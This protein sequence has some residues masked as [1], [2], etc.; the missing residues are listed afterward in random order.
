LQKR[1]N[2][3]LYDLIIVDASDPIG[4]GK[5]LYKT[6]FY[7]LLKSVLR[8][9]G[10]VAVQG[11]SFFWLQGV[12]NTVYHQLKKVFPVV[13]PYQCFTAIYPGGLW[14]LH[15]ATLGDDPAEVDAAV[16]AGI[17]TREGITLDYYSAETH[18]AS[19][20]LPPFAR[21]VLKETPLTLDELEVLLLASDTHP[22][23]LDFKKNKGA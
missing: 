5:S 19:F 4:P 21:K 9:N 15:L 17:R 11:G 12:F 6:E 14:N 1:A 20:A 18:V 10:A 16:A 23:Q 3:T 22:G 7:Q 8:E 2:Q 13:K